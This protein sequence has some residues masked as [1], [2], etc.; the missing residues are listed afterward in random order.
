MQEKAEE[1]IVLK[2][3]YEKVQNNVQ[4]S[5]NKIRQAVGL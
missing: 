4:R 5:L 1:K 2:Y 3:Q